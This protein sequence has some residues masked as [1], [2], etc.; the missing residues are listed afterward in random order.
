MPEVCPSSLRFR[1]QQA[2]SVTTFCRVLLPGGPVLGRFCSARVIVAVTFSQVSNSRLYV[3]TA[4][5]PSAGWWAI[6]LP[7]GATAPTQ[8]PS[9]DDALNS[10]KLNATFLY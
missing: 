4:N 5:L 1:R 8:P 2:I 9:L 3:S 10:G 7:E 6:L